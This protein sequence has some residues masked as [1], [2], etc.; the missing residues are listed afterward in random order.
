MPPRMYR[1]LEK[2]VAGELLGDGAGTGAL[3]GDDVFTAVIAMR[4][5]LTPKCCSEVGVFGR[6]DRLAQ[7]GGDVVVADDHPAL[8]RELADHVAVARQE[9]GDGVGAVAVEG[10][11]FRKVAAVGRGRRRWC[12]G[13]G[14]WEE[15]GHRRAPRQLDDD[16]DAVGRS[17]GVVLIIAV[18]GRSA[19]RSAS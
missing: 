5:M 14:A 9:A 12:R 11:D 4:E 15:G 19:V 1:R 8:G 3:A 6:H 7:D 18:Y 13:G 2:Q 16:S 10:A 17:S